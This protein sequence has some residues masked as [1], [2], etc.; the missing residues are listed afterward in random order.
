M[1][2]R[3]E[4]Q[5]DKGIENG[6]WTGTVVY[7]VLDMQDHQAPKVVISYDTEQRARLHCERLNSQPS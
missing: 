4:V 3:Y 5:V 7:T 1:R 6:R 2:L